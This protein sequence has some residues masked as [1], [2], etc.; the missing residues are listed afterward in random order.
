LLTFASLEGPNTRFAFAPVAA[1]FEF[2]KRA[3]P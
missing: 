3:I 1:T 2:R